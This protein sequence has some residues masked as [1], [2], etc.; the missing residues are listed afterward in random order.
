MGSPVTLVAAM[1]LSRGD[2]VLCA[3]FSLACIALVQSSCPGG[4]R[5]ALMASIGEYPGGTISISASSKVWL[6]GNGPVLHVYY[7][8]EGL[9][10]ADT[11]G[12]AHV[13]SGTSCAAADVVG[14]HYYDSALTNGTDPWYTV[15][16]KEAG[17]T[18]ATGMFTIYSGYEFVDN[19]KHTFV[20]HQQ[21]GT[22]IG[23]GVLE[24]TNELLSG[25][26]GPYPDVSTSMRRRNMD[27]V[28]DSQSAV[29]ITPKGGGGLR[30]YYSLEGLV[31]NGVSG[32][33][34]IHS[35]TTCGHQDLV[36][37]HF[38][39]PSTDAD[40]W[41]ANTVWTKA[42]MSDSASG[43][44]DVDSGYDLSGNDGHTFVVHDPSGTKVKC[45]VLSMV[46]AGNSCIDIDECA[47]GLD[48]CS[49]VCE[50]SMGSYSCTAACGA[51]YA[52]GLHAKIGGYPSETFGEVVAKSLSSSSEAFVSA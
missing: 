48:T 36:G 18:S 37:G 52:S 25:L 21:D 50:N 22:K 26:L 16:E 4:T 17:T 12:G 19:H 23:C 15:W 31:E 44:F 35:G 20:I 39:T 49:E 34:H 8:L 5:G 41:N 51:G 13:H 29:W 11:N 28:W 46:S 30:V 32:G 24:S 27:L 7:H 10:T 47:E 9:P 45:G 14:G 43:F 40:P 38:W 1:H 6:V 33:T 2:G 3:L 42:N